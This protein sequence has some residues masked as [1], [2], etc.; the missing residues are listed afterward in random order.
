MPGF[1]PASHVRHLILKHE[2]SPFKSVQAT[3][4][5]SS[6]GSHQ[7]AFSGRKLMVEVKRQSRGE[8]FFFV[9]KSQKK[10]QGAN[11]EENIKK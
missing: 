10:L 3:F 9:T 5:S 7:L 1:R 4:K 6:P 8:K 11:V 2:N